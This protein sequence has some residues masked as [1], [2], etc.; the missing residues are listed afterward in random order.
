ML[1]AITV[2]KNLLALFSKDVD[3]RDVNDLRV[4]EYAFKNLAMH[5]IES[6]WP[7]V[8]N[9]I[10]FDDLKL[11]LFVRRFHRDA[12]GT[13]H[14]T[15][16][17]EQM[18]PDATLRGAI[19][20]EV[21]RLSIRINS[22]KPRK[23]RIAAAFSLWLANFKPIYFAGLP[24]SPIPDLWRLEADVNFFIATSFLSLYGTIEIGTEGE[25]RKIRLERISYDFTF[26]DLNL[27]FL[28]IALLQCF[29]PSPTRN[30]ADCRASTN[31]LGPRHQS[32]S[33]P[34]SHCWKISA[35]STCAAS[36]G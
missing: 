35:N 15:K 27:Y 25:D 10:R 34:S 8:K 28:G 23:T 19:L 16:A 22:D 33:C 4:C 18:C 5:C 14:F 12:Y 26:R 11:Q 1:D 29:S 31:Y 2:Q 20:R 7:Q 36:I 3:G 9:L 13:Y 17:L 21:E 30:E 24:S 6:S 32:R